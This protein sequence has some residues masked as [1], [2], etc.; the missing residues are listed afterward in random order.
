[1]SL[2]DGWLGERHRHE[3]CRRGPGGSLLIPRPRLRPIL[4]QSGGCLEAFGRGERKAVG[5]S[6][7][8]PG[9]PGPVIPRH[10]SHTSA[11]RPLRSIVVRNSALHRGHFR[12][13]F[14]RT[15]VQPR[16]RPRTRGRFESSRGRARFMGTASLSNVGPRIR[17][18]SPSSG[19]SSRL[20]RRHLPTPRPTATYAL[21]LTRLVARKSSATRNR[22]LENKH[23]W[24][25]CGTRG[26]FRAHA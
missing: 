3:N 1:M 25:K 24:S 15:R 11:M 8:R 7:A 17:S 22:D 26:G 18:R 13:V 10:P 23:L 14:S 16:W 19:N 2:H 12:T 6:A 21:T 20:G 5:L 4:R 9:S